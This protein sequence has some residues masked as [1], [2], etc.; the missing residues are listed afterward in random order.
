MIDDSVV[1]QWL[2]VSGLKMMIRQPALASLNS[3]WSSFPGEPIVYSFLQASFVPFSLP[4]APKLGEENAYPTPGDSQRIS[5]GD[6][7]GTEFR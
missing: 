2:A 1:T 4:T 5:R 6:P 3:E 7:V